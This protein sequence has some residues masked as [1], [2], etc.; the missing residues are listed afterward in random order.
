[1]RLEV[2]RDIAAP[3]PRV[4]A[5]LTRWEEQ[6]RWML[7]A[8][9]VE[10]LTPQ[11]VGEGV[12]VRCPT[13]LLG[14]PVEDVMRVTRWEEPSRL[15]VEHLGRVVVGSGAFELRA[16]DDGRTRLTWWET[17]DPPLGRPGALAAEWLVRPVIAR[18]F[19]RSLGRL[20]ALVEREVRSRPEGA[21]AAPPRRGDGS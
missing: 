4:W 20:A 9:A 14:I 3:R 8:R 13:S 1:M 6:P 7:D 18:L 12:T 19:S 2:T 16:L 17:I 21:R 11:R 5:V 10:V 15:A